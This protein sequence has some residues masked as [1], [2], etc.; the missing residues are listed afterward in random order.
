M[1]A[2]LRQSWLGPAACSPGGGP[3]PFLAEVLVAA[4]P[5]QSWL[6]PAACSPG[7]GPSP[8]LAEVL[9]HRTTQI[10]TQST[11]SDNE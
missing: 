8:F 3:S 4:G 2:G 1:G 9:V 7:G 5:R 11:N 10:L 6:G